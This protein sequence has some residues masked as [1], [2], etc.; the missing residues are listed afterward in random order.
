MI[1]AWK[2]RGWTG[3]R[4]L[5]TIG[6]WQR[7]PVAIGYV[8]E[9]RA[10][11]ILANWTLAGLLLGHHSTVVHTL[12]PKFVSGSRFEVVTF[13]QANSHTSLLR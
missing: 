4:P 3:L 1:V 13:V 10:T 9:M 12:G 6:Q 5:A 11:K 7:T 8:T 2:T